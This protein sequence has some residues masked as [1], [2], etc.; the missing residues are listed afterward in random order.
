[1]AKE[2]AKENL[3]RLK[4]IRA[5]RR[6]VITKKV[7]QAIEVLADEEDMLT[8]ED[9]QQLDVIKRLL[10]GKLKKLEEIDQNVLSLCTLET[11]EH[12]IEESDKVSAK[13]VECQKKI[14]DAVQKHNK[15][16]IITWRVV[17][18]FEHHWIKRYIN[19]VFTDQSD[20]NS[21]KSTATNV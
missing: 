18:R 13:V 4:A 10:D 20:Y 15:K 21:F 17:K 6:G 3:E 7:Q 11:I 16:M 8:D 12:E 5:A 2:D 14:Q 19:T 1:M 9:F